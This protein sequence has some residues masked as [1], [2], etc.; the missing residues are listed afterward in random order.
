MIPEDR[1]SFV[2]KPDLFIA[3]LGDGAQQ[4]AFRLCNHFR[5]NGVRTEMDYHGKSLKSQ[6]KRADKFQCRLTLILGER[7]L[8]EGKAEL[9]NMS[10]GTQE[11]I[12]LEGI[13]ETIL[14]T[15]KAR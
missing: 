12:S 7:E 5:M 11:T 15:A 14:K 1:E 13:E 4:V 3:A 2:S 9:R 6:M 10:Q 8:Q